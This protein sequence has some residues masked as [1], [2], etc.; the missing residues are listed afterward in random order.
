VHNAEFRDEGVDLLD[1]QEAGG[2]FGVNDIVDDN[3]AAACGK[4]QLMV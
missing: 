2:E 1:G 4:V 3:R